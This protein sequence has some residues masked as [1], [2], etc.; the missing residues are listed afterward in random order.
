MRSI[1]PPATL[2][3]LPAKEV[4]GEKGHKECLIIPLREHLYS[5]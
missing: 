1:V 2:V 5:P 4:L 3:Q